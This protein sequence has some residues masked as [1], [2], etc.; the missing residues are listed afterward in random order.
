MIQFYNFQ[1]VMIIYESGFTY[2]LS[3]I[4]N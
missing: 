2:Y 3:A 4:S 1:K